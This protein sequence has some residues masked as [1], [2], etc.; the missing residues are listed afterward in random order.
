MKKKFFSKLV[1]SLAISLSAL[2]CSQD[3]NATPTPTT[4]SREIH[5]LDNVPLI[6]NPHDVKKLLSLTDDKDDE[7]IFNFCYEIG[8]ATRE[9]IKDR[10]F[11]RS[12]IDLAKKNPIA[13]V[14]LIDLKR[15]A[16][17]YFQIINNNLAKHSLSLEYIAENMTHRPVL[18]N[19]DYPE[20]AAIERYE[21]AIFIPNL[22]KADGEKQALLSPKVVADGDR[23]PELED[24]IVTW[25]YTESGMLEE[26]LVSEEASLNTSNPLFIV[27]NA[28]RFEKGTIVLDE[29]FDDRAPIDDTPDTNGRLQTIIRFDSRELKIKSGYRY[30]SAAAS[31]YAI[32]GYRIENN[33]TVHWV[34]SGSG[35]KVIKDI[36]KNQ[37]G[38]TVV[39][40]S[41]HA[42]VWLPYS[43]NRFFWNT[44]ERDWYSSEKGLGTA[45]FGGA[46]IFLSGRRQNT[47]EWYAWIPE[48]VQ[49]HA[50]PFEWYGWETS[51]NFASWKADYVIH[52]VE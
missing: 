23:N 22:K 41:L 27:D 19:P 13:V 6:E 3:E 52:R 40:P 18:P 39:A 9:L 10:T 16:P 14:Y 29:N 45:T 46:T 37:I 28:Q 44:Y 51:V 47:S 50:T 26:I 33:G 36:K 34:Y 20:T 31:E 43:N 30:E 32:Q 12:M 11:T 49:I 7:K 2:S 21:P 8:L 17:Q 1:C 38:S 48:T 5:S 4:K 24:F 15:D 42:H 25:Y 35:W